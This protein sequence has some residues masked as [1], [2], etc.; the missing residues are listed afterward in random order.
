VKEHGRVSDTTLIIYYR[1]R[2]D[3][4]RP[5]E[6]VIDAASNREKRAWLAAIND[7][8]KYVGSPPV[9]PH[10]RSCG[11]RR[12]SQPPIA[13]VVT[14]ERQKKREE[15]AFHQAV[16]AKVRP[17]SPVCPC[18]PPPPKTALMTWLGAQFESAEK[19]RESN[20]KERDALAA[21]Y[22]LPRRL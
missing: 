21:K 15:I 2:P 13:A 17:A 16:I 6:F 9:A 22:N 11:A 4:I 7:A 8:A 5:S 12:I 3:Q 18:P 19:R 1:E 14:E 10:H 20:K